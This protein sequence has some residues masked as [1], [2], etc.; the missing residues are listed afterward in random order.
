MGRGGADAVYDLALP[1]ELA[2]PFV[3]N[4]PHSGRFYPADLMAATQLNDRQIRASE[5]CFVDLLFARAPHLG[6][7]LIKAL[8]P[9]AYVDTNREPYELDPAMFS[10]DLPDFVTKSSVHVHSGL[11]TIPRLVSPEHAIYNKKLDFAEAMGRIERVYMPYHRGLQGVLERVQKA[12]G[13]V[14]LID[15][16]S[17]P[18]QA[19]SPSG[20]AGRKGGKGGVDVILGDRY[21]QACGREL[22]DLAESLF[23]GLGY[24]VGRNDPYAGGYNVMY[25]GRPADGRHVLQLEINRAL[26][27]DE[28][29][30]EPTAN[31]DCL[32]RD[33]ETW[34]SGMHREAVNI[35]P[36]LG[37]RADFSRAAE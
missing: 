22:S 17:M 23:R 4:S 1:N 35:M 33:L 2:V 26:Y 34:M 16:H 10:G 36:E 29:S 3:Y 31:F 21:G 30:L 18:S 28:A 7:P 5:D 14:V 9:R 8:Y 6:A 27:V 13:G 11:G 19:L 24:A 20:G 25:Y 32:A 12:F 15:C 37:L